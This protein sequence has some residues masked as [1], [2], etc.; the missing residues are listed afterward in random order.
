MG[1][2][3][4]NSESTN[5]ATDNNTNATH[6][7]HRGV[8]KPLTIPVKIG[9]IIASIIPL[10]IIWFCISSATA[11]HEIEQATAQVT[12]IRNAMTSGD[13][14]AASQAVDTLAN[15]ITA[16]HAQ[17]TQPIWSL[18]AAIPYYGSDIQAVRDS[19][20]ALNTIAEDG[21]PHLS[22][23]TKL[24]SFK[25]ISITDGTVTIPHIAQI[26]DEMSKANPAIAKANQQVQAIGTAHIPQ[27]NTMIRTAQTQFA[28]V[29]TFMDTATNLIQ[30]MP[31]MMNIDGAGGG[32]RHYVILA[33][34]NAEL[35]V[36]GG[37]V[38]SWGSIDVDN[39]K[40][41]LNQFVS[42]LEF[43]WQDKPIIPLTDDEVNVYGDVLGRMP[44]N[45]TLTP[46]FTRSGV[47]A[48]ATWEKRFGG[49]VDG[50]ISVDPVMLQDLLGV[51]GDVKVQYGDYTTTLNG[52]NTAQMLLSRVYADLPDEAQD[53]FFSV[54]ASS[55]FNK[56]LHSHTDIVNMVKA[57]GSA[58]ADGHLYMWSA[59]ADE[60]KH[61]EA[62][63]ISGALNTDPTQ[64]QAGVYVADAS[65]SKLG[66]YIRRD[67]SAVYDQ[68][69]PDGREKY[70][71]NIEIDNTVSAEKA[72]S[73]PEYVTY[74]IHQ[75]QPVGSMQIIVYVYAPAGGRLA[76]WTFPDGKDFDEITTHDGL[77]V[78]VRQITLAPGQM[79][80]IQTSVI[81]SAKANGASMGLRVTPD[82]GNQN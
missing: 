3:R 57:L 75:G 81:T 41:T 48:K 40:F 44:Q 65:G 59:H 52:S 54:A 9:L 55:V 26:T 47:L 16:A 73:L 11:K 38:G 50:V 17:T 61:I 43:E 64:P 49:N 34:N 53:E 2:F 80:K 36:T 78:G 74:N 13:N 60:Q 23:V 82:S 22:T 14:Q 4:Q 56:L 68:T 45:V 67:V 12:V 42:D 63:G 7:S 51:V 76:S 71:L 18:I 19:V 37:I 46:D 39:G 66:W 8:P 10:L 29:A 6:H 69:Y 27:L 62:A 5:A 15:H 79:Y 1:L 28:T 58:A 72:A 77:T 30:V 21:L 32:A 25:D 31:S 33:Q 35:R 24:L 20:N 70:N